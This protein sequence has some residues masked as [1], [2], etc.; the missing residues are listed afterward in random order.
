MRFGRIF[1]LCLTVLLLGTVLLCWQQ[2][3]DE[4]I[5]SVS[6][7]TGT[8]RQM[9]DLWQNDTG[10]NFVF[11]P[12]YAR[13]DQVTFHLSSKNTILID[14]RTM[15]DGMNC[16]AFAI[17]EPYALADSFGNS[18]GTLTLVRSE[19]IPTVCIEVRSGSMDYI[20]A[21]QKN[22]E[23][24]QIRVYDTGGNTTYLGKIASMGGRGMSTWQAGKKPYNIT[25]EE[26]A[27]LLGMG[28]GKKWILLANAY[29]PSNLRNTIVLDAARQLGLAYT[30]QCQWVDLYL[31]GSYAGLYLLTERNEVAEGRVDIS[32]T[33]SFL[34][35]LDMENRFI[36]KGRPYFKLDSGFSLRIY[37]SDISSEELKALWQSVENA[38]LAEDGIDPNTGKSWEELI[39]LDSWARRYLLE[40]IFGNVDS[41]C[42][43]QAF[44]RDGAESKICAGPVWDYDLSIGNT[45]AWE[46]P[47]PTMSF[48]RLD[49]V[50]GYTWYGKL[51]KKQAF[52]ERVL[53]LYETEFREQVLQMVEANIE[54]YAGDIAEAAKMNQIRWSAKDPWTEMEDMKVYLRARIDFLDRLWLK[55]EPYREVYLLVMDGVSLLYLV[56]EGERL[57][58]LPDYIS[59]SYITYEGWFDY[60]TGE[61]FDLATPILE[62]TTIIL[63]YRTA[64][65]SEVEEPAAQEQSS[66]LRYCPLGIFLVLMA[67]L[68]L[69]DGVRRKRGG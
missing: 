36:A 38:I 6:V 54:R 37:D 33:G 62:D 59:D 19:N 16:S 69:A 15:T 11:L 28:R 4:P 18:L 64:D 34:V 29:D 5:I 47:A 39:D 57:P 20:H 13:L 31:N 65:A 51:Y 45:V 22:T 8:N 24:G 46:E 63:R 41:G 43:S 7:S 42:R 68:L 9:I 27:D 53:E 49:G 1:I 44:F 35:G 67:G 17:N 12:A 50:W 21:D 58:E 2:E 40:E 32:Q 3:Q 52:Y 10:D 56:P 60:E 30:P 48:G 26:E 14:G 61:P 55:R 25:L 23:S 66:I